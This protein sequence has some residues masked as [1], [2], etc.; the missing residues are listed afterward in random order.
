[1]AY[2]SGNPYL[3]CSSD[4]KAGVCTAA[5]FTCTPENVARTCSTFPEMGGKCVGY[6]YFL[7]SNY[8]IY[9]NF[10]SLLQFQVRVNTGPLRRKNN[11]RAAQR[12]T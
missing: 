10:I 3:A 1:M 5:D 8:Y 11:Y 7:S 12:A 6:Y 9:I 4:S 2:D